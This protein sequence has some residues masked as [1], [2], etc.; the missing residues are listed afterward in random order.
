MHTLRTLSPFFD[1][2]EEGILFLERNLRILSINRAA[3]HM[4]GLEPGGI[5]G[6]FC[7]K[8]FAGVE[9]SLSCSK[10]KACTLLFE[11]GKEPRTLE[12]ALNRPDGSIIY[13]RMWAIPLQGEGIAAHCAVILRDR[14][15]EVLLEEKVSGQLQFG[16]MVGHSPVMRALFQKIVRAANSNATVLILGES[17]TG[18]ELVA[19]ALHEHSNR[20]KGPYLQV[21]CAS[22]PENLLESELFGHVKG[23]FT[24]AESNRIGRFEAA[25]GGTLLLDEIGEISPSIQVKLLRVLQERTVERLGEN[26]T[27][28]VDVRV[29]AATNRDLAAMVREGS[30]REDLYYRLRVLPMQVPPLRERAGDIP[31]LAQT[32]LGEMVQRYERGDLQ[33]SQDA[34]QRLIGYGWPGNV[35]ELS[36]ALEYALVHAEGQVISPQHLPPELA[37]PLLSPAPP[38]RVTRPVPAVVRQEK[39]AGYYHAPPAA[40]EREQIVQ[41]LSA[42]GGNRLAAARRLGMSRTTLW[43]RLRNLEKQE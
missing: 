39:T 11:A 40:A 6:M 1:G 34:M 38:E 30:F 35:R 42:T 5:E 20:A 10:S 31:L 2:L 36:N 19:R 14:T 27:H 26:R 41:A 24:G 43:K 37:E 15:R 4:V 21:H 29:V 8:L 17:G 16:G 13:L 23:A 12:L 33:L 3:S 32:L 22:F 25:H 9:C 18:K 7:P 28:A